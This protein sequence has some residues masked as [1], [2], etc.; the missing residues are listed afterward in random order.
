MNIILRDA[1]VELHSSDVMINLRK[2]FV[3]RYKGHKMAVE[4]VLEGELLEQWKEYLKSKGRKVGRDGKGGRRR[5][6][7][8]VDLEILELPARGGFEISKV[9]ESKYFFH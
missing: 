1:F 5:V 3:E 7:A 8:W 4:V 6:D 9:R 2:E